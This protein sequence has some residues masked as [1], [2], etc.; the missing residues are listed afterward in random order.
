MQQ[1][2]DVIEEFV[3][4]LDKEEFSALEGL[5][6]ENQ[7]NLQ[8]AVTIEKYLEN[9]KIRFIENFFQEFE[10]KFVDYMG[11]L[12]LNIRKLEESYPC[13]YKKS[14]K[15]FFNKKDKYTYPSLA[16]SFE[17]IKLSGKKKLIL[18]I[19]IEAY[20][21]AGLTVFDE[22]T[23]DGT[24]YTFDELGSKD[25]KIVLDIFQNKEIEKDDS[26]SL[27][28]GNLPNFVKDDEL[29]EKENVDFKNFNYVATEFVNEEKRT[30]F[31]E[32]SI[33][34]IDENIVK[35]ICEAIKRGETIC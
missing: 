9:I 2:Y 14:L 1:Y 21:Y 12:G 28:W 33:K 10:R 23:D 35:Y 13:Y 15:N 4:G 34:S 19:S 27:I 11:I 8:A 22:K 31:I 3:G 30:S 5:I 26:L 24:E 17:D 29:D 20:I 6:L 7:K 32:K 18:T 25:K 16:Y